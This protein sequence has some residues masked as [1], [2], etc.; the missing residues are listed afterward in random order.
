VIFTGTPEGVG[1][2][3]SPPRFLEPGQVLETWIE[4]VGRMRTTFTT[5]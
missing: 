3:R 2:R 5:I 1:V 4:G